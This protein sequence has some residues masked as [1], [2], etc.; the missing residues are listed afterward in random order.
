VQPL[1][2]DARDPITVTTPINIEFDFWNNVE[3]IP[4]NLS[5]HL[6]TMGGECVFNSSTASI[7]LSKGLHKGVCEIPGNL[8]NDG[9]Y[10]ISMMVVGEASYPLFNF[11]ELVSFEVLENRQESAWHGKWPGLV[12]PNLNFPLV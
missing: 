4:I 11:E 5:M 7:A 10:T 2:A 12:R 8:L 6:Y 9:V 1:L 3:E